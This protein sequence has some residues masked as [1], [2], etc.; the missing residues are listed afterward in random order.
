MGIFTMKAIVGEKVSEAQCRGGSAVGD[1]VGPT[2]S[3]VL[4]K[5]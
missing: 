5:R 4:L 3:Q 1:C 2:P